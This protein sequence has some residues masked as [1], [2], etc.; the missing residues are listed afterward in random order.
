VELSPGSSLLHQPE[1]LGYFVESSSS[2]AAA[3][4][5]ATT[6]AD[7][8]IINNSNINNNSNDDDH[9]ISSC[10]DVD[11]TFIIHA[12]RLSLSHTMVLQDQAAH[13]S[14]PSPHPFAAVFVSSTITESAL[15]DF[16][17]VLKVATAQQ[18]KKS[19]F[20]KS[21]NSS[22][23]NRDD[24]NKNDDVD[25]DFMLSDPSTRQR[26]SQRL[27][28]LVHSFLAR[29]FT[30]K[31]IISHSKIKHPQP[32]G[33]NNI[34]NNN[35]DKSHSLQ[36][37]Q[38]EKQHA[39]SDIILLDLSHAPAA[40]IDDMLQATNCQLVHSGPAAI[41]KILLISQ[42]VFTTTTTTT[43]GSSTSTVSSNVEMQQQQQQHQANV[44]ADTAASVTTL[45]EEQSEQHQSRT[46]WDIPICPVCLHRID[47]R[48][49]G[50][51]RPENHQLCSKFCPPPN[52]SGFQQYYSS[53]YDQ[54]EDDNYSINRQH[55]RVLSD[56]SSFTAAAAAYALPCAQQRL[57]QPW[58]SPSYCIACR[59]IDKYWKSSSSGTESSGVASSGRP[60]SDDGDGDATERSHNRHG[61]FCFQCS[62]Q[63]T[64]WVCLVRSCRTCLLVVYLY[65]AA[66]LFAV[67]TLM[68]ANF[69][70][71][72]PCVLL[73]FFSRL[74]AL[75]DVDDIAT[76]MLPITLW[77]LDIH[78]VWNW[79]RCEYGKLKKQKRAS[80]CLFE[81]YTCT[82][83]FQFS[84]LCTV[85]NHTQGLCG[86]RL[87]HSNRLARMSILSATHASMDEHAKQ[88]RREP[89]F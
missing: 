70:P 86:G 81:T 53:Y 83:Y 43:T 44:F 76:S 56:S 36:L 6:T 29:N 41:L 30:V 3:A 14:S 4:A 85:H 1:M 5:A 21:S 52:Y 31:A 20:R 63:E 80:V 48:R 32:V 9:D 82:H 8:R 60:R 68:S 33:N 10:N 12:T 2:A 26:L 84:L 57:L 37:L 79:P 69:F 16:K 78:T 59:V 88:K 34:S 13:A 40:A 51:P 27:L 39:P 49:L 46:C 65:P 64:L 47:P 72:C 15:D 77:M 38:P 58:P 42:L 11:S 75:L 19:S 45:L 23:V 62:L 61:I 7:G 25:D 55:H 87:C 17:D 74:V 89:H 54:S 22:S 71:P 67:L 35:T 18:K 28:S 24:T 50:L 66:L 73:G